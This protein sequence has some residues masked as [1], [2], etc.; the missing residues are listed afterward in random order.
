MYS[1]SEAIQ[2]KVLGTLRHGPLELEELALEIDEPVF[3]VRAFLK[4][5]RRERLVQEETLGRPA[6][7]WRLTANGETAAALSTQLRLV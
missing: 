4:D 1:R 5:L 3:T 6:P 7:V 2:A